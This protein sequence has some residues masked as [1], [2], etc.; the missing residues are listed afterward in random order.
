MCQEDHS[1][2]ATAAPI[3]P[4]DLWNLPDKSLEPLMLLVHYILYI[5]VLALGQLVP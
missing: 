1:L 5:Q 2:Q 4:P 3:R